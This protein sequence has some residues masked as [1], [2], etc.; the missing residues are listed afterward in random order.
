MTTAAGA[1]ETT[2]VTTAETAIAPVPTRSALQQAGVDEARRRL[3]AKGIRAPRFA[4]DPE[5]SMSVAI[6]GSETD[7][8]VLAARL[9]LTTACTDHRAQSVVLSQLSAVF[10]ANV[11]DEADAA[12][13]AA[14]LLRELGPETPTEA[15]LASQM[16]ATQRVAMEMLKRSL[17]R[18]QPTETVDRLVTRAVRLQR[19]FIEQTEA[20]AKLRGQGGHQ[21]VT[22]EHV[23]RHVHVHAHGDTGAPSAERDGRPPARATA[24]IAT[25]EERAEAEAGGEGLPDA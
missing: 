23:H 11:S 20:L 2:V 24:S 12:N 9:A 5:R 13:K 7:D 21:R 8:E 17:L 1:P 16:I 10:S 4:A 22:V 18:E 14:A 19:V 3:E 25:L 6:D 15:L